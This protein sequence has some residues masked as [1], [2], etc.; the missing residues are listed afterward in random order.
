VTPTPRLYTM[1]PPF[2]PVSCI[3]TRVPS[4]RRNRTTWA[5]RRVRTQGIKSPAARR[6]AYPL[7]ETI[8]YQAQNE[9]ADR[10]WAAPGV[11]METVSIAQV[12]L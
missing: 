1:A 11:T 8:V 7:V 3:G 12:P 2:S 5:E 4:P 10:V 9:C 6:R